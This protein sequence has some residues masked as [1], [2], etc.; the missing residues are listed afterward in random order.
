M[1]ELGIQ[2]HCLMGGVCKGSGGMSSHWVCQ[3]RATVLCPTQEN[4]V[5]LRPLVGP[6]RQEEVEATPSS[7]AATIL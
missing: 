6:V 1:G 5:P 4:T 2:T 7:H 3:L